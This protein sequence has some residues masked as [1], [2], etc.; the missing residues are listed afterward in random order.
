MNITVIIFMAFDKRH[1]LPFI[2]NETPEQIHEHLHELC[3]TYM[4]LA[5]I[6]AT[7]GEY[8]S[9]QPLLNLQYDSSTVTAG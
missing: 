5:R 9:I 6:E 8:A 3:N 1:M 2:N 7:E 4:P